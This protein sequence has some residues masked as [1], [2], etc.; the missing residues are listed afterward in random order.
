MFS[1]KK[2]QKDVCYWNDNN[3]CPHSVKIVGAGTAVLEEGS[4]ACCKI[5]QGYVKAA[6]L[7]VNYDINFTGDKRSA[8]EALEK[9][10]RDF[11]EEHEMLFGDSEK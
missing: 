11:P 5:R 2:K 3:P 10:K 6:D 1:K 4:L 7:V 9:H 8:V